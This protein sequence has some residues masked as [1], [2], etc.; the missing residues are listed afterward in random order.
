MLSNSKKN[1]LRRFLDTASLANESCLLCSK[2]NL[3]D[4]DESC[5][6]VCLI[7][8]DF[9]RCLLCFMLDK[10]PADCS[11]NKAVRTN[12]DPQ[13]QPKQGESST[14]PKPRPR[15]KD[16]V[17]TFRHVS[18]S[19]EPI[20]KNTKKRKGKERKMEPVLD[21]SSFSAKRRKD[22]RVR[23]RDE[24][25]QHCEKCSCC[26]CVNHLD[27]AFQQIR[28]IEREKYEQKENM[29][30]K[31]KDLEHS[32]EKKDE[33]IVSLKRRKVSDGDSVANLRKEL[34]IYK[35]KDRSTRKRIYE[36]EKALRNIK[37][38]TK[39]V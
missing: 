25:D 35:A 7:S 16:P 37:R 5:P 31:I 8:K 32:I 27:R 39:N 11:V 3:F 6:K 21:T 18:S 23:D 29:T 36:L 13:L 17:S 14:R 19:P 28:Q 20:A 34:E 30:A 24:I 38:C 10:T 1:S 2:I 15:R 26:S 9:E 22:E 33:M 4:Q 12:K